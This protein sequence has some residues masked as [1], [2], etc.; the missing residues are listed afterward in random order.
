MKAAGKPALRRVAAPIVVGEHLGGLV[1]L[2]AP[3]GL[4]SFFRQLAAAAS[5]GRL[6]PEAYA[7]ASEAHG[8]T[9][10]G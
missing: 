4:E 10:L 9:W 1:I 8:I 3:A 5:A 6:G 2:T 7:N